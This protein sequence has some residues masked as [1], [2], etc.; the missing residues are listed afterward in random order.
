MYLYNSNKIE[1]DLA[2]FSS[3]SS[4]YVEAILLDCISGHSLSRRDEDI[5]KTQ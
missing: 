2:A 4:E 3:A 1:E 5:F